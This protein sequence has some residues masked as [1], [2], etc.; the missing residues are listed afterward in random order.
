MMIP[1]VVGCINVGVEVIIGYGSEYI[2]KPR[3]Y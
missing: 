1:M 3:N 2:S